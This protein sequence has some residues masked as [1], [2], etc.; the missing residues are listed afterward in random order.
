[1]IPPA[2]KTIVLKFNKHRVVLGTSKVPSLKKK[3]NSCDSQAAEKKRSKIR[4][5][6]P[7]QARAIDQAEM[8]AEVI[9]MPQKAVPKAQVI[10]LLTSRSPDQVLH[11][12]VIIID[13][14]DPN[15]D[16]MTT[17]SESSAIHSTDE[18]VDI[19]DSNSSD[20][21][22]NVASHQQEVFRDVD[23]ELSHIRRYM[24][25]PL[26]QTVAFSSFPRGPFPIFSHS[27]CGCVRDLP[28][29]DKGD[30]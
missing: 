17:P 1:M 11:P 16:C 27:E 18:V 12:D 15:V 24:Y 21:S 3:R 5:Q 6:A 23:D 13:D 22:C 29:P 2:H 26:Q 20:D 4:S 25:S 8:A 28:I 9:N 10:D 14:S 30:Q 7:V 19:T